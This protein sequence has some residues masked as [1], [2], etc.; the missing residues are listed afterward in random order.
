M[1]PLTVASLATIRHVPAGDAADAGDDAGARRVAVVHVPGGQ[2]RQLEKRRTGIDQ[3]VDALA[4]GH[5]AL[6]AMA[7]EVFGAAALADLVDARAM[8]V[9]ERLHALAVGAVGLRCWCRC[10]NEG[11]PL[12]AAAVGLEAARRAAPDGVHAIHV[13]AA[14]LAFHRVFG[15]RRRCRAQSGGDRFDDESM[16][17]TDG[18]GNLAGGLVHVRNYTVPGDFRQTGKAAFSLPILRYLFI[19]ASLQATTTDRRL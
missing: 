5:L 2:R 14:A 6:L 7:R 17:G 18:R 1:P 12:P 15:R 11:D 3:R 4:H 13:R 16:W 19:V 10:A 9:D 8:L